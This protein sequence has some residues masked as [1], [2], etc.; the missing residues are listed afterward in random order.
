MSLL[1]VLG[2]S[3]VILFYEPVFFTVKII[4]ALYLIYLGIKLWRFGIHGSVKTRQIKNQGGAIP[5]PGRL[6]LQGI[7]LAT[8]NPK[9]I[10]L[11]TALIPQFID[12]EL[13]LAPQFLILVSVFMFLSFT[14]LVG[15]ALLASK[16]KN[17][18]QKGKFQYVVG[19]IFGGAFISSGIALAFTTQK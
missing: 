4:G 11:T 12:A 6:Y 2:L 14:S 7:L 8:S 1:A 9:A 13:P 18:S 3:T 15:F 17:R 19:K 10:A 16:A 5:K